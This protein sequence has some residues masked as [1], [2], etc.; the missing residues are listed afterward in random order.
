MSIP[1][2]ISRKVTG[3]VLAFCALPFLFNL[4]GLDFASAKKPFDIS[5]ASQLSK[6]GVIDSMFYTLRGSFTHTILEWS[7]FCIA[8]MTAVLSFTHFKIRRDLVTP[9]I[10]VSLLA[11]GC[12][13]AFHTLAANR[14][15]EATAD[16][17][18]L[19]PFTWA[20]CRLFN[21][22]ILMA[23]VTILM[24]KGKDETR[25]QLIIWVSLVF[26]LMAYAII[27]FCATH[28]N[29]P[30]T[31][32]P[33]ALITRPWDVSPLILYVLAGV[34]LFPKFYRIY[35]SYFSLSLLI[36]T[37]PHITT[38][39]HMAFG[40][41]S[42]FDNHFNIA[43]F[44]KIIAYVVP[45]L[46]LMAEYIKTYRDEQEAEKR[47]TAILNSTREAII[48]IDVKGSIMV[49]NKFAEQLFGYSQN[50]VMGKNV[51]MLMPNPYAAE[52]NGYL[53]GYLSTGVKKIIGMTRELKGLKKNGS[54]FPMELGISEMRLAG[55]ISFVGNI[56]DI[57]ES[58]EAERNLLA[59][60]EE[61]EKANLAKSLF[62]ANMSHEIR[63][64][65]NA[66]LGFSQ[67]LLRNKA[68]DQETRESIKTIDNSGKNLFTMINEILDISKIEAGKMEL[69]L[70]DFSLNESLANISSLFKLRTRQKK[71][72]W[73]LDLPDKE[74]LVHGDET[75]IKQILINLIG[76]AVKFTQSG[77]VT[78]NVTPLD[79]DIFLFDIIDTGQGI[80]LEAQESI[81]E[82]F[83]QEEAG[84]KM[85]GTGLGLTITKK[86]L[87]LMGSDLK[88]ESKVQ[89]GSRFYFE[90]HLPPAKDEKIPST[91]ILGKVLHM[92]EG[93]H[94]KILVVDDIKENRDVLSALLKDIGAQV[95][96]A[97][98]GLQALD[99]TREHL[100]DLIFMDMRMPKM[101]GE[102]AI[103]HILKEF[104]PDRFKIVSITASAFDRHKDFY[105]KIGCHDYISKPFREEDIFICLKNLLDIDYIYEKS[106]QP[107]TGNINI[108][109]LDFSS[110]NIPAELLDPLKKAAELYNITSLEK[111][112]TDL[113]QASESYKPL[114]Q[115]LK[116]LANQYDMEGIL[117]VL[118][119][120]NGS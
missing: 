54:V 48:V 96:E 47:I 32:Y 67:I 75:R 98:D 63:T 13:D 62:L 99:K 118:N 18:N 100:P 86:Q 21:V 23:G 70:Y 30:Q 56:K 7:A 59:A 53:E 97:E 84:A 85:G 9:I 111:S 19:I 8:F 41:T 115:H 73:H 92:T 102:E 103:E 31:M 78:L 12:M 3:L 65:L 107:E 114:T 2:R 24:V 68:L 33:D 35:P 25:P 10:G 116:T 69:N 120:T 27:H 17:K 110:F 29:L 108:E 117:E 15:I 40:S 43:H 94:C 26:G 66:I 64:P 105:L 76:N 113:G 6:S 46:G 106:G 36:S 42:L 5:V 1:I 79:N 57:S 90:L 71:L 112:L 81:F 60:K 101:R 55:E 61:A 74:H 89:I 51:N 104:G 83:S 20:I 91:E 93:S 52:H 44:L 16:N 72:G 50:D 11:A 77:E 45:F 34:W 39:L 14:L 37:I 109:D 58:K 80:P 119:K 88:L 38:Q 95:I 82:P 49:F 28:A 4:L 87:A 22:L